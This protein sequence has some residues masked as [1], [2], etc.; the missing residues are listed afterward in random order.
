MSPEHTAYV[1]MG[2]GEIVLPAGIAGVGPGEALPDRLRSLIAV[3]RGREI[4]LSPIRST[5]VVMGD[6]KVALP[7]R[8]SRIVLNKAFS[9]LVGGAIVVKRSRK[10]ALRPQHVADFHL[11]A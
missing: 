9:D 10:I 11:C 2:S 4:T 3:Q 6:G 8:I 1:G 7:A 5:K